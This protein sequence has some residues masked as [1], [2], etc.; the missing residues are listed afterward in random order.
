M[1]SRKTTSAAIVQCSTSNHGTTTDVL[2]LSQSDVAVLA[3]TF[4]LLGDQSRLKILLQCMR[5]SRSGRHCWLAR[6]VAVLGQPSPAPVARRA[7]RARRAPSQAHLLR[8]C[9][10]ARQPGTPGHGGSHFGGQTRR[11]TEHVSARR[12]TPSRGRLFLAINLERH[13]R[14]LLNA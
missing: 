6:P 5:G 9:R 11:L 12:P 13:R 10:P 1:T 14:A 8:H 2:A 7:P 4:R 3:E